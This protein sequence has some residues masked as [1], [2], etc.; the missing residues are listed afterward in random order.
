[1]IEQKIMNRNSTNRRIVN[2][3]QKFAERIPLAPAVITSPTC[4]VNIKDAKRPKVVVSITARIVTVHDRWKAFVSSHRPR[5]FDKRHLWSYFYDVGF[6]RPQGSERPLRQLNY[7]NKLVWRVTLRSNAT[8]PS[9]VVGLLPLRSIYGGRTE[10]AEP[11][12][13]GTEFANPINVLRTSSLPTLWVFRSVQPSS[14]F[15]SIRLSSSSV[16]ILN[17]AHRRHTISEN[18]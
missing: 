18:G 14:V 11:P 15:E 8:I 7:S 12:P 6:P 9:D 17:L 3:L 1:V 5:Y 4:S 10:L 13:S 16:M 2:G